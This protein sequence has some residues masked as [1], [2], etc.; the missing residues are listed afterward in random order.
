MAVLASVGVSWYTWLEQGRD[1]GVT[2][3]VLDAISAALR[4]ESSERSH[5]YRLAGHNAPQPDAVDHLPEGLVGIVEGW[6]PAPAYV[7]D[8]HCTIR[9]SNGPARELL[10]ASVEAGNALVG[11]F[12]DAAVA[13]RVD[14]REDCARSLVASFRANMARYPHD[15]EFA[16]IVDLLLERSPAFGEIWAEQQVS[17]EPASVHKGFRLPMERSNAFRC[18]CFSRSTIRICGSCCSSRSDAQPSGA[19]DGLGQFHPRSHPQQ[20]VGIDA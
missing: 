16:R 9:A 12:T 7:L 20:G 3:Q 17:H 5:L 8:R 1:I 11:F 2:A 4:L 19:A 18:P 15:P 6:E 10:G 14:N 13:A